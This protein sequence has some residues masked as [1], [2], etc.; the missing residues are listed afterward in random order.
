MRAIVAFTLA[1]VAV[2]IGLFAD[3]GAAK[4]ARDQFWT[5]PDFQQLKVDRIALFP[6]TSYD[7]SIQNENM[8]EA[9]LGLAFKSTGYRW[10]SGTST[11]E[12]MRARTGSDSML[13]ALRAGILTNARLDSASAAGLLAM[14]RCDAVLTVRL[15][16]F[17]RHEPEWNVAGKPYTTVQL[18]AAV[19]DPLGRVLWTASGG[20]TG[21]GPYYDPG[22]NPVGVKDTGLERKPVTGQGGAPSY[23]EVLA[24]LFA[25]W[26]EQFPA[27]PAAP[28]A[29]AGSA[30]PAGATAPA[31]PAAD[32]AAAPR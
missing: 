5:R 3:A 32:S 15:D 13:K 20:E 8:V 11:R 7:N 30:A 21:E 26:A 4:K 16:Q 28:T 17:E 18:K 27:K 9:A 22:A 1:V 19:V 24:L 6:V 2:A 31:A 12:M 10:M 23:R 25:R 14:L 29:P